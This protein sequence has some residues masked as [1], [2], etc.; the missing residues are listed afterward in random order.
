MQRGRALF[1][2]V[3][4]MAMSAWAQPPPFSHLRPAVGEVV[5]GDGLAKLTVPAD[6]GY[7][8][9]EEVETVPMER[10]ARPPGTRML[11]MV[12]PL[13][14]DTTSPMKRGFTLEYLPDGHVDD[15]D[16]ASLDPEVLLTRLRKHVQSESEEH[17]RMGRG[18][19]ALLGWA[20]PPRYDASTRTVS[21]GLEVAHEGVKLTQVHYHGRLLGK[22]GVLVLLGDS[23]MLSM[24]QG[25][26]ELRA[27]LAA[28]HFLPGHRYEDFKP[29]TDRVAR[30]GVGGLVAPKADGLK[31]L[32]ESLKGG[33]RLLYVGLACVVFLVVALGRHF[34]RPGRDGR[35]AAP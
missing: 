28:I 33:T 31:G 3:S 22:D 29:G 6:F 8:T 7:L 21:W 12:I 32:L 19:Q 16:A 23:S 2:L 26:E 17:I 13:S 11:G 30:G 35:S 10:W 15:Q 14:R 25:E 5:L 1:V 20:S 24:P 9:P 34:M 27:V 4:L 18:A